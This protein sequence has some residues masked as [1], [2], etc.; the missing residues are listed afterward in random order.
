VSAVI[1]YL[2][3]EPLLELP[4][5]Y[6]SRV[7]PQAQP[8]GATKDEAYVAPKRIRKFVIVPDLL[9]ATGAANLRAVRDTYYLLL[10]PTSEP[11]VE[12]MRRGFLAFVIEPLTDK[13]VREVTAIR[14]KAS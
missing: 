1:T 4:P 3:T 8:R 7:R 14:E 2:H 9:N 5:L 12:A 10:G 11:N 13:A 6:V